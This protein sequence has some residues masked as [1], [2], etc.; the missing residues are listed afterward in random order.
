MRRVTQHWRILTLPHTTAAIVG[1]LC[2]SALP[3]YTI[4]ADCRTLQR[5]LADSA[6][7]SRPTF[8]IRK[9][10]V[11]GGRVQTRAVKILNARRLVK[12]EM[13]C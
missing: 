1:R 5:R 10:L 6:P 2:E 13:I 9:R 4:H 11:D 8:L 12:V 7:Q 3:V